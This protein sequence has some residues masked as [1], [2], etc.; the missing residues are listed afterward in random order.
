MED[1]FKTIAAP[2]QGYYTEKRS[3][4]YAFAHHVETLDQVKTILDGYR[5]Q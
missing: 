5:R 1:T 2:T 3:K 4:F